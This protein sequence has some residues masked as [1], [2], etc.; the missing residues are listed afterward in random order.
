MGKNK[1]FFPLFLCLVDGKTVKLAGDDVLKKI[2][3][4]N[5]E[6]LEVFRIERFNSKVKR[7]RRLNSLARGK[8][9]RSK[10]LEASRDRPDRRAR[11]LNALTGD[12]LQFKRVFAARLEELQDQLASDPSVTRPNWV[13]FLWVGDP[14]AGKARDIYTGFTTGFSKRLASHLGVTRK[15]A[16][17]TRNR[18]IEVAMI[19]AWSTSK[20]KKNPA[21]VREWELKHRYPANTKK[22]K[23]KV[24]EEGQRKGK[25]KETVDAYN[26]LLTEFFEKKR[27]LEETVENLT[28]LDRETPVTG[29]FG[30]NA[31]H[32]A[33]T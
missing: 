20:G 29:W 4:F 2:L 3:E 21:R 5:G 25:I 6:T 30:Q 11:E 31:D 14:P 19:E 27:K 26:A 28:E 7:N 8:T 24:I 17:F 16:R 32:D 18:R 15:G 1:R 22:N 33:P 23:L 9:L 12:Y 10:L 13:Y